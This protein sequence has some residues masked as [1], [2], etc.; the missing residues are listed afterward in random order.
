MLQFARRTP[1]GQHRTSNHHRAKPDCGRCFVKSC[2]KKGFGKSSS[3][4]PDS[5]LSLSGIPMAHEQIRC[6]YEVD[7]PAT[8]AWKSQRLAEAQIAV[9]P[10]LI[11]VPVDFERDE[12]WEEA[13]RRRLSAELARVFHLA[14]GCALSDRGRYQPHSGLH[15]VNPE[16]G[17][18][19]RLHGTSRGILRRAKAIRKGA[20]RTA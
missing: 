5:R 10:W 1:L 15:V 16:L 14:R 6:I 20:D 2:R 9:P 8:Q 4:A 7:H 3:S 17:G 12:M 19:V 11:L 18:G 13:R